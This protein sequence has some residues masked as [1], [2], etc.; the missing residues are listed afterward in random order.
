M[1]VHHHNLDY[2]FK[3]RVK[4]INHNYKIKVKINH[5]DRIELLKMIEWK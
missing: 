4:L 1:E 3:T 5:L 2:P